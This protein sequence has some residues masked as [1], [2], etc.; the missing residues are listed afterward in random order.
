MTSSYLLGLDNSPLNNIDTLC[1]EMT[2]T[3]GDKPNE[4]IVTY[5]GSQYKVTANGFNNDNIDIISRI[6][7]SILR[8]K[9]VIPSLEFNRAVITSDR[10]NVKFNNNTT[11]KFYHEEER[12]YQNTASTEGKT[13]KFSELLFSKEMLEQQEE[14]YDYSDN[15]RGSS[16][17]GT[18]LGPKG[19][20]SSKLT[21]EERCDSD[22]SSS[23]SASSK[24]SSHS[25]PSRIPSFGSFSFGNSGTGYE[26]TN[27]SQ[28]RTTGNQP[29]ADNPPSS[30]TSQEEPYTTK[31]LEQLSTNFSS[32]PCSRLARSMVEKGMS[33][34]GGLAGGL[35]SSITTRSK[36]PSTSKKS[37]KANN[38]VS[39]YVQ[40]R[41]EISLEG[42]QK[43][44]ALR[45]RLAGNPLIETPGQRQKKIKIH[46]E[47]D[48]E[49]LPTPPPSPTGGP[50]ARAAATA[51]PAPVAVAAPSAAAAAAAAAPAAV[52]PPAAT[53]ATDPAPLPSASAAAAASTSSEAEKLKKDAATV[54]TGFSWRWK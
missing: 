13:Q 1:K 24:S 32:M 16:I 10:V 38:R 42:I 5:S 45:N 27:A 46:T 9:V 43:S 30:S 54:S 8:T 41:I 15:E 18:C 7:M 4:M 44:D 36:D 52:I 19:E 6:A 11:E 47:S 20:R 31:G 48:D 29:V 50:P 17:P 25:N 23:A 35:V 12:V 21:R 53:A 26:D 40:P 37:D 22:D 14:A 3:K 33:L 49:R 39:K 2:F 51:A 28:F 34:A